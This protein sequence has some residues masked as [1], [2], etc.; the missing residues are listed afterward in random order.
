MPKDLPEPDWWKRAVYLKSIDYNNH[1]I[2]RLLGKS[3]S[4]VRMAVDPA[5]REH[6][7]E[8]MRQRY[9]AKKPKG[10]PNPTDSSR[11]YA[12]IE[13]RER[14]RADGRTRKLEFY[15]RDLECL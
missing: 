15:Y 7:R 2:A 1:E 3:V 6:H 13:A 10:G 11:K 8:Y 5:K 9:A 4:A 14:W 12:R